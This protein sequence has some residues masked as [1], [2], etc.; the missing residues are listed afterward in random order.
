MLLYLMQGVVWTKLVG[1][2]NGQ[3]SRTWEI[4][5]MYAVFS[6]V[7]WICVGIPAVL[8]LPVERV[9]R[10]PWAIWVL[11][12]A[13]LGPLALLLILLILGR[14]KLS[15]E[16]T[17]GLWPFA[18]LVSTVAFVVY[19]ALVRRRAGGAEALKIEP[20]TE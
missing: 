5:V 6:F 11:I 19:A 16:H 14:G 9:A 4:F 20:L 2:N 8:A 18:I 7:G 17:G 3:L 10:C 12:G 15:L 13:V 1:P